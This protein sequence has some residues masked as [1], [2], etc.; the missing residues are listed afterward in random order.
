MTAQNPAACRDAGASHPLSHNWQRFSPS[1]SPHAM[2]C[3]LV[4]HPEA[5]L[6]NTVD[7]VIFTVPSKR[8]RVRADEMP[9]W[10]PVQENRRDLFPPEATGAAP[11][12]TYAAGRPRMCTL[13]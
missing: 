12:A 11:R 10:P 1:Y 7:G 5:R 4:I 3:P 13:L 6:I 9:I 8:L 2:P